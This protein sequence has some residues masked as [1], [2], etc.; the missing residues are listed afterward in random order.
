MCIVRIQGT[1]LHL[2]VFFILPLFSPSA[3]DFRFFLATYCI[4]ISQDTAPPTLIIRVFN[5]ENYQ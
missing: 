5:K 3:Y 4:E 1:I 2:F